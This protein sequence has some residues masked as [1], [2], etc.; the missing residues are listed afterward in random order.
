MALGLH[1]NVLYIPF[2]VVGGGDVI[3]DPAKKNNQTSDLIRLLMY[4]PT[5]RR[6]LTLIPLSLITGL[7]TRVSFC[8][9]QDW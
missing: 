3:G 5:L 9:E 6:I 4:F 8:K 7:N 1:F 2:V